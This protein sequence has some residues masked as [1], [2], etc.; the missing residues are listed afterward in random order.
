MFISIPLFGANYY[1]ASTGSDRNP[2]TKAR[3]WQTVKKAAITLVAG[4]TVLIREGRYNEKV[5][6]Q[7][8]GSPGNYITY[9]AY[10][11]ETV[12]IDGSGISLGEFDALFNIENKQ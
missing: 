12:T 11:G 1:V 6:P 10:P 2:G 3:P 9:T 5:S 4:D 8:S 7:N